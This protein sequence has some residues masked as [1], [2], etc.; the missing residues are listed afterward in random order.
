MN[1]SFLPQ[2]RAHLEKIHSYSAGKTAKDISSKK[3]HMIKLSSN[4]STWGPSEDA[5]NALKRAVNSV[6]LYPPSQSDDLRERLARF[7]HVLP[8]NIIIGNGSNEVIQFVILAYVSAKE[9]VLV[10]EPTFSMYKIYSQIMNVRVS[11][12]P[13]QKDHAISLSAVKRKITA[14]TKMIFLS[15]P[16]NPTGMIMD[17]MELE[18][19]LMGIQKNI[20]VVIDEA[21]SD[22]CDTA[23]KPDFS[24]M[25]RS[26]H[27]PNL[28]VTR[29]FSKAFGMAGLRLGYGIAHKHTIEMLRKM[30]QHFNVNSMAVAAANATL[31]NL[32]HYREVVDQVR[33][34]R[35][36]LEQ[37]FSEMGIS[38]QPSQAN[39]IMIKTG[40]G[41][42]AFDDLAER[43][44]IVREL[45]SFG[46]PEYIR[47]T[48][49]SMEHNKKLVQALGELQ[50]IL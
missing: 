17:K 19:F 10:P 39:F 32:S 14:R 42:R 44:I 36:Y 5:K 8:E 4:E 47:V 25:L 29:T 21:Y 28:I 30:G 31:E 38:Y 27:Y 43:G 7:S 49:S 11:S 50:W 40:N 23:F 48:V 26:G 24:A 3:S 16:N 6:H 45:S 20:V 35:R 34:G 37:K 41:K 12:V 13:H 46:M 15:N 2:A 18:L 22:F 33:V 9:H 1:H